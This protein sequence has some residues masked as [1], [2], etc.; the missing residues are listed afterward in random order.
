M[1]TWK[2]FMARQKQEIKAAQRAVLDAEIELK[3][4][5]HKQMRE[6]VELFEALR[7]YTAL[8][9]AGILKIDQRQANEYAHR[10]GVK[11]N[12]VRAT[13]RKEEPPKRRLTVIKRRGVSLPA[14]PD[15]K[16]SF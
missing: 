7:D 3:Q 13:K 9:V 15:Y 12:K 6:R 11:L 1:E 10:Y 14:E 2:E 16:T 5:R 8:Q 4:I